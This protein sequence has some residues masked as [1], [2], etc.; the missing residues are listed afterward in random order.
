MPQRPGVTGGLDLPSVEIA[1]HASFRV[2]RAQL[3]QAIRGGRFVASV[4][5]KLA[6]VDRASETGRRQGGGGPPGRPARAAVGSTSRHRGVG[7]RG[8]RKDV[9]LAFV[10]Q[11][12]GAGRGR[13]LGIGGA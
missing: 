10:D 12:G 2:R 5:R 13:R 6:V 1:Y 4:E 7:A 3:I 8:Q 9:S 11:R